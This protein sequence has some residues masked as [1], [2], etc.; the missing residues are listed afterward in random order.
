MSTMTVPQI[1][2]NAKFAEGSRFFR[3]MK[4]PG[5][6]FSGRDLRNSDF[7]SAS[8]I[9]ANF[10]NCI[11][12]GS[13]FE[14]AN[15][16]SAIF[17]GADCHRVNFKDTCLAGAKMD[18]KDM[19]GVTITLECKSFDGLKLSPGWWYGWLFYAYLM[20]APTKD[21]EEALV[22]M[23]GPERFRVLRTQYARR[24]L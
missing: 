15:C 10:S 2:A 1:A 23:L 8:L 17:S 5:V 4:L 11:L 21:A 9:G 16:Q 22:E 6:D 24:R 3:G 19:Y 12:R 7:R 20:D 13:N 18:A 14:G